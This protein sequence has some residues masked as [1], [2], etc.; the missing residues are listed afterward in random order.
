MESLIIKNTDDTPYVELNHNEKVFIIKGKSLPE[1][2]VNFYT[3]INK[4]LTDYKKYNKKK[5]DIVFDF[6]L[7]YFNTSSAKQITKI[8]LILQ[9]LDENNSVK[10]RWFYFKDDDD[11]Q[12]SGLRFSRLIKLN[13]ELI[14]FDNF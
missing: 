10:I 12:S 1:E 5:S 11:M 8:L 14:S 3:P 2:A 9:D 6:R 13:F 4:W 7:D